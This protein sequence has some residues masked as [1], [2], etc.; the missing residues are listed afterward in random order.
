MRSAL[1]RVIV[2]WALVATVAPAG[3]AQSNRP[4]GQANT[5]N[6]APSAVRH[7]LDGVWAVR[8][9]TTTPR[10]AFECCL[11]DPRLRPP[12]TAWGQARFDAAVPSSRSPGPEG[13]RV[14]PGKENDPALGLFSRR[15]TQDPDVARA[16]RDHQ[17]SRE[18][19]DVL[20]EGSWVASNL[21]G[22]TK[23]F[24]TIPPN[25]GL[26]ATRLDDGMATRSWWSRTVST[27]GSGSITTAIRT[28]RRCV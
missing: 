25:S 6:S 15:D 5:P 22:W 13:D 11:V 14:I 3:L 7:D 28:A 4:S 19:P 21:D 2:S 27:T 24:S 12:M 17:H 16:L 8:V 1:H 10:T 20:R 18:G 23:A 26:T 9:A